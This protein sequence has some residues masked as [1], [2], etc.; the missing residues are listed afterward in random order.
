MD[1]RSC[2]SVTGLM[3]L[4]TPPSGPPRSGLSPRRSLCVPSDR[5]GGS[6]PCV[7]LGEMLLEG[8]ASTLVLGRGQAAFG[9]LP[10]ELERK[11]QVDH[12]SY[13]LARGEPRLRERL[14]VADLRAAKI[15]K[16]SARF[17][18]HDVDD[19]TRDFMHVDGLQL[20][21]IGDGNEAGNPRESA[22]KELDEIVELGR[23]QDRPR[24]EVL[25]HL[26]LSRELGPVVRVADTVDADD[27][28]VYKMTNVRF[29]CRGQ[30][31]ACA[32]HVDSV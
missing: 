18:G 16:Q 8:D 24:H 11:T 28:H 29:V 9:D 2:R 17:T 23:A 14:H 1:R 19:A 12:A 25:A 31:T 15:G 7:L 10:A 6:W 3:I 13:I 27:G 22:E 4:P 30:Q 5:P 21:V 20:P 32:S 26:G